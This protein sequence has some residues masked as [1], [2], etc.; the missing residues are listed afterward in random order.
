MGHSQIIIWPNAIQ[1]LLRLLFNLNT[2]ASVFASRTNLE[3][4]PRFAEICCLQLT[5]I[6]FDCP[7]NSTFFI[8]C[9]ILN[10]YEQG[11]IKTGPK[12]VVV[13]K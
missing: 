12:L 7:K 3:A 8:V 2:R 11:K 5:N 4:G 1:Y 9:I 13:C 10:L 6:K